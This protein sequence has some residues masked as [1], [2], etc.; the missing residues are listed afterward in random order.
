MCF[1][2]NYYYYYLCACILWTRMI[3]AAITITYLNVGRK[4]HVYR[5]TT[6]VNLVPTT[7]IIAKIRSFV[8]CLVWCARCSASRYHALTY[9]YEQSQNHMRSQQRGYLLNTRNDKHVEGGHMLKCVRSVAIISKHSS[10]NHPASARLTM[11]VLMD[12]PVR[13]ERQLLTCG[14]YV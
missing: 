3:I 13:G 4:Q 11:K 9:G 1:V 5:S 7:L 8:G 10:I 6:C 12:V 14:L 2:F